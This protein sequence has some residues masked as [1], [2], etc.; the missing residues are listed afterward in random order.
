MKRIAN[1]IAPEHRESALQ[2]IL[3]H[4][5]NPDPVLEPEFDIDDDRRTHAKKIRKLALKDPAFWTTWLRESGIE[6]LMAGH[7]EKPLLIKHAAFIK[8][9]P[10]ESFIPLHQDIALW[11]HPYETAMTAWVA[12]TPSRRGNGGMFYHPDAS[13]IH[14]H[15]CDLEY[16]MFKCIPRDTPHLDRDALVDIEADAGDVLLWPSR[17]AHGSHANVLG[18]LRVGM[19]IV[20]VEEAEFLRF[21]E[22]RVRDWSLKSLAELFPGQAV[23]PHELDAQL[24][25]LKGHSL[26]LV[27]FLAR[28]ARRFGRGPRIMDFIARPTVQTLAGSALVAGSLH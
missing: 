7:L 21:A 10:S 18:G 26:K 8:R 27:T 15:A 11:E 14:P 28:F 12:L 20:Y 9:Q 3:T 17:T 24:A 5:E 1:L 16:P 23:Q 13:T 19:P 2:W 6:A 22:E 25:A 4:S